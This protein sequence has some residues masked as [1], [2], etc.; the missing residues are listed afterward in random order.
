MKTIGKTDITKPISTKLMF[1]SNNANGIAS[2][3]PPEMKKFR[4]VIDSILFIVIP[5]REY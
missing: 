3:S 2:V 5:S 1:L 4:N